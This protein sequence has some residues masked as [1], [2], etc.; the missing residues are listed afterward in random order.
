MQKYFIGRIKTKRN[1]D[2]SFGLLS[3]S[4]DK[5]YE[6]FVL[7]SNKNIW[8]KDT[9]RIEDEFIINTDITKYKLFIGYMDIHN[10]YKNKKFKVYFTCIHTNINNCKN[11][12]LQEYD[13][14]SYTISNEIKFTNIFNIDNY[15]VYNN[16]NKK[17]EQIIKPTIIELVEEIEN[18]DNYDALYKVYN[19]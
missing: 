9:L 6:L 1:N 8:N 3:S 16:L 14:L 18:Y 19:I 12:L 2:G 7:N 17:K 15:Y 11:L 4:K 13:I 5:L 10:V